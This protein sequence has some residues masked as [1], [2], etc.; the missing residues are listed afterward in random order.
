MNSSL[1]ERT[2][3][4]SPTLRV[5]DRL[6]AAAL[7]GCQGGR[8]VRAHDF[9][10]TFD[11]ASCGVVGV[12]NEATPTTLKYRLA[13]AV[14]FVDPTA[15]TARLRCVGGVNLD[16]RHSGSFGLVG[17]KRAELGERPRMQRG[18][19]GLAKPYPV[20]DPRQFFDGDAASGAFSHGHDAFGNLVIDVGG[21]PGL[22]ATP[23]LQQPPRRAGFLCLQPFP[24]P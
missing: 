8:C 16:E 5:A 7:T 12:P 17:Q 2:C 19:L 15:R 18:P 6:A 3:R 24:Q 11:T 20:T 1:N 10:P 23:L 14:S 22:F 21:E 13:T 9:A 4:S